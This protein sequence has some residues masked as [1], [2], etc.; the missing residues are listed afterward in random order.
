MEHYTTLTSDG[1]AALY[2]L[3]STYTQRAYK[4]FSNED[5]FHASPRFNPLTVKSTRPLACSSQPYWN[6]AQLT[7]QHIIILDPFQA[8]REHTGLSLW[9]SHTPAPRVPSLA[10]TPSSSLAPPIVCISE[11][12]EKPPLIRWP[13]E[14]VF[15][16]PPPCAAESSPHPPPLHILVLAGYQHPAERLFWRCSPGSNS[17]TQHQDLS[18]ERARK[19]EMGH[20]IAY[21][22]S[23]GLSNARQASAFSL[24]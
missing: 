22:L 2:R 14:I 17:S 3:L 19:K 7:H 18:G 11:T 13:S 23:W 4:H 16:P 6:G 9:S 24:T 12:N 1:D 15:P 5:I 21:W 10:H 8:K 20:L